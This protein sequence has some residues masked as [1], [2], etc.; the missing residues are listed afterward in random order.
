MLIDDD[1]TV[2]AL[3]RAAV[4]R[5]QDAS[6]RLDW[7]KSYEA[8]VEAIRA[9]NHD[10]Y[11]VDYRL[12][13]RSGL[14]LIRQAKAAGCTAPL[15]L[16]TAESERTVDLTALEAGADDFLVKGETSWPLID[17]TIRYAIAHARTLDA[18][19]R[20]HDRTVGL[21]EIARL[22][23][24]HAPTPET[25]DRLARLLSERFGY[26]YVSVYLAAG[27]QFRLVAQRGYLRPAATLDQTDATIERLH[28]AGRPTLVANISGDRARGG[29]TR[30]LPMELSAPLIVE[31][32]CEGLLNLASPEE[33][34]LGELDYKTLATVA[35][36]LSV[37]LQLTK[38]RE[39]LTARAARFR[40]L[41]RFAAALQGSLEPDLF[42]Q[43][44][45][46]AVGDVI[47]AD[48]V[49]IGTV[50]GSSG[51]HTVR[52]ATGSG[53]LDAGGSSELVARAIA[54]RSTVIEEKSSSSGEIGAAPPRKFAA[55]A[56][57]PVTHGGLLVGALR[58]A[59]NDPD[60]PFTALEREAMPLIADQI[61]LG[62]RAIAPAETAL[63]VRDPVS[64]LYSRS[65][66][67]HTLKVLPTVCRQGDYVPLAGIVFELAAA[68]D[69]LGSAESVDQRALIEFAELLRTLFANERLLARYGPAAFAVLLGGTTED[70]LR[71]GEEVVRHSARLRA[72][73]DG[74]NLSVSAGCSSAGR[75]NPDLEAMMTA[76]EAALHMAARSGGNVVVAG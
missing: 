11:L 58:L 17:R 15:I 34:P 24:H 30:S 74:E 20:S 62:M 57:V 44:V 53:V 51:A 22:L 28:R 35:D 25:I 50:D 14:D 6:Y 73:H 56:V 13:S 61:A 18:L 59:R 26:Q 29:E 65:F 42:Y 33:A 12:G 32:E 19:K 7:A 37:A 63:P 31:G 38:D 43:K 36:R 48:L 8:G 9:A 71:V 39:E 10:A 40:N 27:K 72:S 45:V 54:E 66:F 75:D 47:P 21:E 49:A 5:I 23:S 60:R 69:P 67:E 16:L 68:S 76:A 70:A 3:L 1:E 2:A 41:S 64:G 46:R 52:A 4:S 55:E